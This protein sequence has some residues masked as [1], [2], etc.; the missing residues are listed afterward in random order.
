[1][2]TL[3]VEENMVRVIHEHTR[4][5][6]NV[7]STRRRRRLSAAGWWRRRLRWRRLRWGVRRRWR[8]ILGRS[9]PSNVIAFELLSRLPSFPC[10][11]VYIILIIRTLSSHSPL[12]SSRPV[13]V[14]CTPSYLE[15]SLLFVAP[16]SC[17]YRIRCY[18]PSSPEH[19]RTQLYT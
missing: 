14:A 2:D 11:H 7:L 3:G 13:L 5:T 1:M 17:C 9:H 4:W 19:F 15:S 16:P 12:L 8:R 6:A 18:R 10:I